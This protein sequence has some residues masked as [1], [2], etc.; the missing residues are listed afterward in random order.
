MGRPGPTRWPQT[1]LAWSL[2]Q[3]LLGFRS[4]EVSRQHFANPLC[5][6]VFGG[7]RNHCY[8][9]SLQALCPDRQRIPCTQVQ[10]N[11]SVSVK[12]QAGA[13]AVLPREE[14]RKHPD[15]QLWSLP[16]AAKSPLCP[17]DQ[18]RNRKFK[19]RYF[20]TEI[21]ASSLPSF[22]NLDTFLN[23]LRLAFLSVK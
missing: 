18:N 12:V 5:F 19:G 6:F 15:N 3:L 13:E 22:M 10:G 1:L 8:W 17:L 14:G 9:Q 16:V 20:G 4:L 7:Y 21:P 23:S 11:I 2:T